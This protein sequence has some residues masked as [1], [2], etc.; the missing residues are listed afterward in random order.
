MADFLRAEALR[1]LLALLLAL[2]FLQ[3]AAGQGSRSQ[4]VRSHS[5]RRHVGLV[6]SILADGDTTEGDSDAEG[7]AEDQAVRTAS[8]E[9]KL[10][11][12]N[13]LVVVI[14]ALILWYT[15]DRALRPPYM[16]FEKMSEQEKSEYN[17]VGPQPTD[18]KA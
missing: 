3:G 7:A 13:F 5:A 9:R 8:H 18:L 15:A 14:A 4:A 17:E 2:C 11:P 1:P 10:D 16:D 12:A 6:H